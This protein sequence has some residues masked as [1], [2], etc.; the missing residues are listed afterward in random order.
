MLHN[1]SAYLTNYT[2]GQFASLGGDSYSQGMH[3]VRLDLLRRFGAGRDVLD[4][5]CGAGA[6][7]IPLL[8]DVRYAVGLDFADNM[9]HAFQSAFEAG[10]PGNLGL[11]EGD[12]TR[13]PLADQSFDFA[14]SF[15]ALYHIP[16]VCRAVKEI[17]RVLRVGGHCAIELGN[18][19]S[20]NTL[21]ANAGHRDSGWAKPYHVAT[22]EMRAILD[23]AGLMP[24]EWRCFQLSPMYGTPQR[25][26]WLFPLVAKRWRSLAATKIG[27]RM[28]D[29]RISSAWPF[30][31]FA[32]R[33]LVIAIRK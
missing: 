23:E 32:F 30:R 15:A 33:H 27:G 17:A 28:L 1:R 2:P 3:E 5:C 29:E 20:L 11:V 6:Y 14:Y 10:L 16:D 19:M 4:V 21:V 13:M 7:L 25:Y 9:L 18:Q 22:R 12:A 8:N 31:A 26:P 24:I